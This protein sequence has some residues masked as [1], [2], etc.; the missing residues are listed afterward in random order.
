[1]RGRSAAPACWA[2]WAAPTRQQVCAEKGELDDILTYSWVVV[3]C[4]EQDEIYL[5]DVAVHVHF[6]VLNLQHVVD[7]LHEKA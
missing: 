4:Q 1:M 5:A 3:H 6:H 7:Y 2:P